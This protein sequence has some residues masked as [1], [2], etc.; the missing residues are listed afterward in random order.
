MDYAHHGD[1]F[2]SIPKYDCYHL[3][4]LYSEDVFKERPKYS[5]KKGD[6][7][8]KPEYYN[9]DEYEGEKVCILCKKSG[10]TL[11]TCKLWVK[12]YSK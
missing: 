1:M 11:D 5:V 8:K 10:H 4:S 12:K 9:K 6:P 3:I 2:C 7:R